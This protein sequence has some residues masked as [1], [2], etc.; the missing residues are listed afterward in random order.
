MCMFNMMMFYM[1]NLNGKY[2]KEKLIILFSS[3]ELGTIVILKAV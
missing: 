1:C 3:K 2:R